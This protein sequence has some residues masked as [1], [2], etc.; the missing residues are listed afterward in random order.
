MTA[1]TARFAVLRP[2]GGAPRAQVCSVHETHLGAARHLSPGRVV[3]IVPASTE[4]LA[5]VAL[6][7]VE[8][9]LAAEVLRVTGRRHDVRVD[10]G[11]HDP[12]VACVSDRDDGRSLAIGPVETMLAALEELPD[13][14]GV[15]ALVEALRAA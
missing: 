14:A 13:G 3:G 11:T 15:A 6:T 2:I 7:T 4:S 10:G 9:H 5:N 1:T 12:G 8:T